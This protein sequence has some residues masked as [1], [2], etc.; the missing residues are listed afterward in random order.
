M[1]DHPL[2]MYMRVAFLFQ[3]SGKKIFFVNK[4]PANLVVR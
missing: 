1:F 3:G 2:S 4:I